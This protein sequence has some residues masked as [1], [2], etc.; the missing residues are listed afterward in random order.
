MQISKSKPKNISILC[1]FKRHGNTC[2]GCENA[3]RGREIAC[4]SHDNTCREAVRI[5]VEAMRLT[6]VL[7]QGTENAK[8]MGVYS[9]GQESAMRVHENASRESGDRGSEILNHFIAK[10]CWIMIRY[11]RS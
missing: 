2:R 8:F 7:S 11:N 6:I 9:R 10:I 5:R 3:R 4:R 1:T